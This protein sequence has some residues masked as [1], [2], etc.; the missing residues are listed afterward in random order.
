MGSLDILNNVRVASPCPAPWGEM[1][2]DDRVR[3]C[4]LCKKNVYDFST[5]TSAEA[6]ALIER[7]GGNLCGR[8]YRRRDGTLI[9]ADCPVGARRSRRRRRLLAGAIAGLGLLA[10][11]AWARLVGGEMVRRG[12]WHGFS[13]TA[14]PSGPDVTA[15]DYLDW[16]QVCLGL[17]EPQP[18]FYAG[19]LIVEDPSDAYRSSDDYGETP[20]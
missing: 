19:A 14:P 1:E 17:K 16:A 2:G 3:F 12:G 15:R 6:V 10:A 9:T 13:W 20:P 7:T 5:L 4:G 18:V 11:G 8:L